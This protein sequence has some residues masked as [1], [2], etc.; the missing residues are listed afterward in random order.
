MNQ[1]TKPGV[2]S[3][4]AA[5]LLVGSQCGVAAYA[6]QRAGHMSACLTASGYEVK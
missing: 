2:L 1:T 3:L 4:I 5:L 6:Q